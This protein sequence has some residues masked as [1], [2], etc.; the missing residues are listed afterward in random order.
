[1]MRRIY[2]HHDSERGV[3]G[4]YKWLLDEVRE[5]GGAIRERKMEAI[6]DECAD[7]MAWLASLTNLLRVD[8]EACAMTKYDNRCPKCQKTPCKCPF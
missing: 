4:T 8:L 3:N 6:E 5:L 2:F 7:V 1:M